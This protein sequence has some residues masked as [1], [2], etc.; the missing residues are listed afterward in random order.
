MSTCGEREVKVI[1][2]CSPEHGTNSCIDDVDQDSH[3]DADLF[4]YTLPDDSASP[5][6]LDIN[7]ALKIMQLSRRVENEDI[8][9]VVGSQATL[10]Q[11]VQSAHSVE[12]RQKNIPFSRPVRNTVHQFCTSSHNE[13]LDTHG[14][15]IS[16]YHHAPSQYNVLKPRQLAQLESKYTVSECR[17]DVSSCGG[18]P[19]EAGDIAGG[20]GSSCTLEVDESKLSEIVERIMKDIEGATGMTILFFSLT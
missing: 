15:L 13:A 11:K 2:G 16:R 20:R 19:Y 8:I 14:K 3:L 6:T 1:S 7:Q 17:D 9:H 5:Q 4:Q 18:A 12:R 10:Q